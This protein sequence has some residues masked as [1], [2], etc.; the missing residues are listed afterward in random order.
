MKTEN[1][2]KKRSLNTA[3]IGISGFGAAHLKQLRRLEDDGEVR[4]LAATVVNR[5]EVVAE[6]ERLESDGTRI[7]E[8]YESMLDHLAEQID[9]V[10]IPTGIALHEPMTLRAL[11]AGAHVYLEKPA[12]G[13]VA[14]I[15]RMIACRD[16]MRRQVAAGFQ[17]LYSD[18]F[19][20]AKR[21]IVDGGIG[22]VRE[23]AVSG[24]WPRKHSYYERNGWAG[25]IQHLGRNIHDSP[26]NNA[27][28]HFLIAGLFLASPREDEVAS[29]T[30][31]KA[32]PYRAKP[33]EN[34]DTLS[35]LGTTSDGV[36]FGYHVTHSCATQSPPEIAVRGENGEVTWSPPEGFRFPGTEEP[37]GVGE[38][39]AKVLSAAFD[40]ALAAIRENRPPRCTLEMARRHT[41]IIES[42]HTRFPVSEFP[43]DAVETENLE[44][45]DRL[46]YVRG[47]E[48][49]IEQA[50]HTHRPLIDFLY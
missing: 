29:L 34:Y 15:D 21:R 20:E 17:I 19:R 2:H 25:R 45:G 49:A 23:V 13:S 28:S 30:D 41:E 44:D 8:D 37:L 7:F 35:L 40:R 27:L 10:C 32:W 38:G 12:A 5:P 26:A 48:A 39:N 3:L 31:F 11:E 43:E 4:L 47:I 33:I 14:E 6:C 42:I 18:A 16:R 1:S 9:L 24:C 50:F 22:P 36:R 46:Q